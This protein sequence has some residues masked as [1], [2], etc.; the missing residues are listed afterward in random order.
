MSYLLGEPG[1]GVITQTVRREREG[2]Y[3]RRKQLLVLKTAS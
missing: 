1:V 2:I 3:R